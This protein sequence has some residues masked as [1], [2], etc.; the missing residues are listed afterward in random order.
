MK[1]WRVS[2]WKWCD[3]VALVFAPTPGRAKTLLMDEGPDSAYIYE[4]LLMRAW[5]EPRFDGV[6]KHEHVALSNNDLPD[7]APKDFWVDGG[8]DDGQ[9]D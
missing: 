1:A 8:N 3:W 6:V 2:P 5:R 4:F 7:S 9:V